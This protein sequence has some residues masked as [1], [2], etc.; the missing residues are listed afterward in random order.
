VQ[1]WTDADGVRHIMLSDGSM[2]ELGYDS[3]WVRW[4]EPHPRCAAARRPIGSIE[5]KAQ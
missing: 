1:T 2:W 5:I 4:N 3:K